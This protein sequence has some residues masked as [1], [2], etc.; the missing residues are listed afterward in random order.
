[1]FCVNDFHCFRVQFMCGLPFI[2]LKRFPSIKV[3][4]AKNEDGS[5]NE[6]EEKSKLSGKLANAWI[7]EIRLVS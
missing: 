4:T 2:Y 5:D 7:G 1:M 3:I 6:T